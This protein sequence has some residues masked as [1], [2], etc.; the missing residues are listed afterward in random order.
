MKGLHIMKETIHTISALAIV[1]FIILA[2]WG[3]SDL[4]LTK[5]VVGVVGYGISF[6]INVASDDEHCVFKHNGTG[7]F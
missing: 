6:F 4:S 5:I 7:A 2:L 3:I 1:V